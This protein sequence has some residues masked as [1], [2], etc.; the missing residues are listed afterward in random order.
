MKNAYKMLAVIAV[1]ALLSASTAPSYAHTT[2]AKH[3]ASHHKAKCKKDRDG[4]CLSFFSALGRNDDS[5]KGTRKQWQN[6][7]TD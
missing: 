1:A 3:K 4:H 2:T 7:P 5:W 6:Q